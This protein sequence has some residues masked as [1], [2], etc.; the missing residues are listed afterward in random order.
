MRGKKDLRAEKGE[1][2]QN[3]AST[4]RSQPTMSQDLKSASDLALAY[5]YSN[6]L[7]ESSDEDDRWL[8]ALHAS[9]AVTAAAHPR[10][11]NASVGDGAS[12]APSTPQQKRSA[13]T[14]ATVDERARPRIYPAS[15]F[16]KRP[17]G[18]FT[19][20]KGYGLKCPG[21]WECSLAANQPN[22]HPHAC[23][24]GHHE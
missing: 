5:E 17:P 10:R 4:R 7:A 15:W 23:Q 1:Y 3:K 18:R 14:L 13:T 8:R 12:S 19:S 6:I 22:D 16:T 9:V 20:S 2:G 24:H 21:R 11:K